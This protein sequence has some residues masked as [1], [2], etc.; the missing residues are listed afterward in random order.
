MDTGADQDVQLL[1]EVRR[2]RAELRDS[3]SAVEQALASPTPAGATWWSERLLGAVLDLSADLR[4]HVA[5]TEG[6]DGLYQELEQHAPRLIGPV[7][8]L[9][10]EHGDIIGRLE[11]LVTEL[12]AADDLPEVERVRRLGTD[13]LAALMRHRQRG[14]DL[15][16]EA[17][18]LDIGGE[19]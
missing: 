2:R 9:T 8:A 18:D 4:E 16:F 12:E 7:G 17:Y 6:P 14:A 15:V 5:I 11:Q 10:R 19:T 13:L 1:D 3:M